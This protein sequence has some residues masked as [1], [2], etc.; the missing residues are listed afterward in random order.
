MMLR[1]LATRVWVQDCGDPRTR[2]TTGS[3]EAPKPFLCTK[4]VD[5]ILAS[6]DRFCERR[7]SRRL[8]DRFTDS[9]HWLSRSFVSELGQSFGREQIELP[10]QAVGCLQ[11][12]S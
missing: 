10:G 12:R 6:V 8:L 9:A 11:D 4:T 3:G 5:P 1:A 7:P 2:G